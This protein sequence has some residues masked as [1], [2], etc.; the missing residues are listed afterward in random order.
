MKFRSIK[1]NAK[2]ML[3]QHFFRNI[4]VT[5]I[6]LLIING[7]YSYISTLNGENINKS[8]DIKEL[9][10]GN[11]S[12]SKLINEVIINNFENINNS[13]NKLIEKERKIV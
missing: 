3:R 12:N 10:K 4:I 13:K 5:F 9:N 11:K 8:Y 6:S 1:N 2:K 7:G